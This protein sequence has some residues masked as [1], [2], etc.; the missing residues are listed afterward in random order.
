M[1]LL[2]SRVH[3]RVEEAG[4]VLGKSTQVGAQCRSPEAA[5]MVGDDLGR[6]GG[7]QMRAVG[8]DLVGHAYQRGVS[9]AGVPATGAISRAGSVASGALTRCT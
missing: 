7:R 8:R 4:V 1:G 6:L 3:E 2:K 5:Q 9:H